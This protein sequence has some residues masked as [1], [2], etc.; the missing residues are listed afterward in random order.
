MYIL[1]LT[2]QG[3]ALIATNFLFLCIANLQTGDNSNVLGATLMMISDLS[4][5]P[6][7]PEAVLCGSPCVTPRAG[8]ICNI[9]EIYNTYLA[10]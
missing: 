4:C 2:V 7:D 3:Q 9:L 5:Q 6:L 8:Q 1:T 10:K